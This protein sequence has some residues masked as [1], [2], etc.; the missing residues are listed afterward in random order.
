MPPVFQ[1]YKGYYVSDSHRNTKYA[2]LLNETFPASFDINEIFRGE[3]HICRSY[4]E[5]TV[6]T[7]LPTVK[8]LVFYGD[9]WK[10]KSINYGRLCIKRNYVAY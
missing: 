1:K 4:H 5:I 8:P 9:R 3:R 7:F 2:W 10:L 6:Y